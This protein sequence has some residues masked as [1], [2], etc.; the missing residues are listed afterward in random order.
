MPFLKS[1]MLAGVLLAAGVF[2]AHAES[3]NQPTAPQVAPMTA[4]EQKNLDMVLTWWR[5]VIQGR[6]LDLSPKY[7]AEDYIQHNPNIATGRAAFLKF[8]GGFGPPVNPIPAKLSPEPVVRGARGDF[9]WLIWEHEAKDPRDAS[10]TY[11]YNS[12]DILRI[13]NGKVQEHWDDAK[14]SP[15]NTTVIEQMPGSQSKGSTGKL[16]KLE[17]IT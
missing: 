5:E 9:V 16:S 3:I 4:S 6:H 11:Y 2:A 15:D 10:K 8:F 17:D 14:K 7:Q 12:F 13:Q 1:T